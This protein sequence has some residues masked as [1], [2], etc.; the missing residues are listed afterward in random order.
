MQPLLVQ[1]ALRRPDWPQTCGDRPTFTS[2]VWGIKGV[3]YHTPPRRELFD[4]V[5][6]ENCVSW[7]LSEHVLCI[8]GVAEKSQV[9]AV[10]SEVETLGNWRQS[11]Q[12]LSSLDENQ[13]CLTHS[14]S[15]CTSNVAS[16]AG[17]AKGFKW[18]WI[19]PHAV[20]K[21]TGTSL[22][23]HSTLGQELL[24][25]NFCIKQFSTM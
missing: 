13:Q 4:V 14:R 1:N 6:G 3:C 24:Y 16:T 21:I 8:S 5:T 19:G 2:Q 22:T 18:V 10:K 12:R 17:S 15:A 25:T 9:K 7:D 20:F 23:L 11:P